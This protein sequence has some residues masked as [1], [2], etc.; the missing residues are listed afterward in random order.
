MSTFW[1]GSLLALAL[2][3]PLFSLIPLFHNCCFYKLPPFLFCLKGDEETLPVLFYGLQQGDQDGSNEH[4]IMPFDVVLMGGHHWCGP[5]P[6]DNH[7]KSY[8][9]E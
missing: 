1:A 5:T 2:T 4:E 3:S 9:S 8:Q 6:T 7:S